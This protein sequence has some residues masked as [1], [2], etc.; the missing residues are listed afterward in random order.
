M[1]ITRIGNKIQL[2]LMAKEYGEWIHV[3]KFTIHESDFAELKKHMID[4]LNS[5]TKE[6]K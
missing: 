2:E 3:F 6:M 5:F 4:S 1:K